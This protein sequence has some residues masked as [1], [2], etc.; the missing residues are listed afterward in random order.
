MEIEIGDDVACKA[1]SERTNVVSRNL[2]AVP[3]ANFAFG[4]CFDSN[5]S[6]YTVYVTGCMFS[7]FVF[8]VYRNCAGIEN[9]TAT[10]TEH[11]KMGRK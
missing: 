6:F 2:L 10:A 11:A 1:A 9:M 3:V 4:V 5:T 7:F 8:V